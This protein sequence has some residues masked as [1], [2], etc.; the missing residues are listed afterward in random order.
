MKPEAA[1]TLT[2]SVDEAVAGCDFLYTDVWVSMGEPAEVW[3]ERVRLMKPYQVNAETMTKTGNP[4]TC[5]LHC[6]PAFHNDET[7]VGKRYCRKIWHQKS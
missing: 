1:F 6:L 7:S 5:F 4:E 2:E 3:D